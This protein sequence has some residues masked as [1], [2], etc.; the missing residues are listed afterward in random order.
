M[1]GNG[2]FN[3]KRNDEGKNIKNFFSL[4]VRVD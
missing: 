1:V 2:V 4:K 3:L